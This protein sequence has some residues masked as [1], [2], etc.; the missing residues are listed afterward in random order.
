MISEKSLHWL[1]QITW[2][3]S[4]NLGSPKFFGHKKSQHIKC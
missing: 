1:D 3:S 4:E 2:G